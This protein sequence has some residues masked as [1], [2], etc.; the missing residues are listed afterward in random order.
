MN[1]AWSDLM[2]M[3]DSQESQ[4]ASRERA[5]HGQVG[6][7]HAVP[8]LHRAAFSHGALP[9]L[10]QGLSGF[11]PGRIQALQQVLAGWTQ[12]G[13]TRPGPSQQMH[14]FWSQSLIGLLLGFIEASGKEQQ[15]RKRQTPLLAQSLDLLL[16]DG[17][18]L[19]L[20]VLQQGKLRFQ[21]LLTLAAAQHPCLLMRSEYHD[22]QQ[23]WQFLRQMAN[24]R[25]SVPG[26]SGALLV[27]S[28]VRQRRSSTGFL[29][30]SH[31]LGL[32]LDDRQAVLHLVPGSIA[33]PLDWGSGLQHMP[34]IALV[35]LQPLHLVKCFLNSSPSITD[36]ALAEQ[37]L[38]VQIPPHQRPT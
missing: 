12:Q 27:C 34:D 36:T 11:S 19:L 8:I 1:T 37:S 24:G 7:H 31:P 33:T 9:D 23:A 5:M 15:M 13:A 14:S 29:A 26:L 38:L 30:L 25:S 4:H 2:I 20:Q 17:H 35:V 22:V 21:F 3:P 10:Q 28:D 18:G 6:P 32:S 16:H